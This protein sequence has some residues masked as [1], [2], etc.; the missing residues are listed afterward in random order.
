MFD[1][2]LNENQFV[3]GN[4]ISIADITALCAID[5][6][7]MAG[8]DIPIGATHLHRWYVMMSSRPSVRA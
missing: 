3:A 5:F 6:A 8:I 7:K 2:Q 1:H 4:R